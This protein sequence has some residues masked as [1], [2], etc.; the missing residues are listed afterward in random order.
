MA[1]PTLAELCRELCKNAKCV[2]LTRG[3]AV[4]CTA[5]KGTDYNLPMIGKGEV[6]VATQ[7]FSTGHVNPDVEVDVKMMNACP[8]RRRELI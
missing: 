2:Q 7:F 8:Y 6:C 1:E 4:L 3:E 5:G